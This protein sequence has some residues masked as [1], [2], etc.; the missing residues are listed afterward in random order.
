MRKRRLTIPAL[1]L[2]AVA[3]GALACALVLK[4]QAPA[5]AAP[6]PHGDAR[7]GAY[8]FAAA[9]C[10]SC[11][12]DGKNKGP[13]LAGGQPMVTDFGTF[14]AP[15]IT[16]DKTYGLGGWSYE[17]FHRAIRDGKGKGG[18]LLY[19]VFPYPSFSGM[20]DQDIADLWAYLKTVPA[21]ARPSK[22]HQVK[23]PYGF[24]PLLIGWRVLFFRPG[25]LQPAAGL[26][27]E[28]QRGRYLSEAVVHCQECH[29]PRNGLGGIERDKA[30]AGNPA[31][32]DGQNAP[33]LTPTGIGK[34]TQSDLRDM[35]ASGMTPD[36]DFLGSG[37]ADVVLGTA[38]LTQAD[39]DAI[40]AYI[41]TLPPKPSTPK[42][43]KK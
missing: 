24:R 1:R 36:G 16:P 12:T 9:D 29:S 14:F 7:R 11:H 2:S 21:V 38:K 41:R 6:E 22:P 17:D 34:L 18:E 35:L 31:G 23:A 42:P 3:L 37:M 32:P 28:Q 5:A 8:V 27:P 25:P 40:I 39:R 19:P 26:T 4:P 15:N 43:P 20:T 30:Y 13:L 33:N 10:Q